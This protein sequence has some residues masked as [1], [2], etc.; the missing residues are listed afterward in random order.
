MALFLAAGYQVRSV[1]SWHSTPLLLDA[2]NVFNPVQAVV[3]QLSMA[4]CGLGELLRCM[5]INTSFLYQGLQL[6]F[7]TINS[8]LIRPQSSSGSFLAGWNAPD[9]TPYQERKIALFT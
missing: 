6:Q 4:Y 9:T 7:S 1:L 2:A 3:S 5:K 8:S